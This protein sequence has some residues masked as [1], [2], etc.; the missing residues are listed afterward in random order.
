M[1]VSMVAMRMK[2]DKNVESLALFTACNGPSIVVGVPFLIKTFVE[3]E[4][5][6]NFCS[7]A[8]FWYFC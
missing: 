1:L 6:D 3:L 8:H 5:L 7:I 2:C 4:L